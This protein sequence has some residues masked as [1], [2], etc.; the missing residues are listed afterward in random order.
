VSYTDAGTLLSRADEARPARK[1]EWDTDADK[2]DFFAFE[3]FLL[4]PGVI[5]C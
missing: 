2:A 5:P 4:G 3:P 1:L